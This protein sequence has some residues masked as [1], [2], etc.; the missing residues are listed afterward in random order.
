MANRKDNADRPK[1]TPPVEGPSGDAAP[2]VD[3]RTLQEAQRLIERL[4]QHDEAFLKLARI[5]EHVNRGTTLDEVLDNLYEAAK[6]V[7]PYDRIG[8]SLIDHQRGVAVA[9]WARSKLKLLLA[10]GYEAPLAGSTLQQIIDTGQPRIINDLEAYLREKPASQNT[11]LIV[12]EGIRSSL[13]CP[14]IVQGT[15]VGFLFFSSVHKNI[16]SD[17]HVAFFQQVASQLATIVEKG[18]LYSELAEHQAIIEKQNRAMAY[19]LEM[20]R[21]VQQALIPP[22]ISGLPGV[23]IAFAYEPATQVGGDI[24][25]II[26][27]ADGRLLLFVGDAMGHGV[28]AALV[29][30]I[31]KTAL[32][33]AL[34]FDP[35]PGAVLT[36]INHTLA[37]FLSDH[38][39]TAVC[40][41]LEP[42]ARRGRFAVAGHPG[43]LWFQAAKRD[44]VQQ[45]TPALPL[46]IAGGTQYAAASLELEA[47]DA[48]VFSTDGIVEAFDPQGVQYGAE[49]FRANVR[50]HG[51]QSA[52]ELCAGIQ[53]DHAKHCKDCPREDDLTLLVVKAVA[54]A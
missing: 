46:G 14:L 47:G 6:S 22:P 4:R 36:H 13:T 8:F 44:V 20:A 24:L 41:L 49:R 39:V 12:R 9:R 11:D 7:I 37:G 2:A 52:Q 33:S 45:G 32:Y 54:T 38:F 35:H 19:D 28:R 43:P 21:Q 25:D 10:N 23:E 42:G 16:Y 27:L 15:A 48:L 26:P 5:T 51:R 1:P 34:Q 17:V 31:V 40:C 53:R 50:R 18:R 30:S 3:E 29:M